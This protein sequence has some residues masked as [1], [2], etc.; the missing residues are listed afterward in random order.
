MVINT[1][2]LVLRPFQIEDA[3]SFY[4]I[5]QDKSIKEFVPCA[6]PESVEE[7]K[8]DIMTYY[9]KGDFVH[10][11]YL[12]IEL[13]SSKEIIGALIV[14]Q[15]IDSEFD[16][17]L[18]ISRDYRHKGYMSEAI[19]AFMETMPSNS[20]LIFLVKEENQASLA[21]M[22]YLKIKEVSCNY[23]GNRKFLYVTR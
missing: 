8:H 11:F 9:S 6:S 17:C 18:V 22:S 23:P 15:N 20:H 14:T 4:E 7:A 2:R 1:N 13:K 12:I 21:L 5:T 3:S 19:K 16:M 10:D